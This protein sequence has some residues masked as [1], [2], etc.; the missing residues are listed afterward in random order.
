MIKKYRDFTL[1]LKDRVPLRPDG[2]WCRWTIFNKGKVH[3]GSSPWFHERDIEE[4]EKVAKLWIDN[5]LSIMI[6]RE[7]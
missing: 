6:A 5:R 1:I 2:R 3:V 4:Y 7:I